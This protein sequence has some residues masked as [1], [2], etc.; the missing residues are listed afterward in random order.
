MTSK[1]PWADKALRPNDYKEAMR[2][3]REKFYRAMGKEIR[4]A[5]K[6]E[7]VV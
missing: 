1:I 5:L 2:T 3:G 7:A 4:M 6:K